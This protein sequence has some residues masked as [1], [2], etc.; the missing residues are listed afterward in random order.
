[1]PDGLTF[2]ATLV[3]VAAALGLAFGV[4][5]VVGGGASAVKP[6]SER[7]PA[8]GQSTPAPAMDLELTA[9]WAIPA[10]R[11][12]SN[13]RVQPRRPTRIAGGSVTPAFALVSAPLSPAESARPTPTAVPRAVVPLRPRVLPAPKPKAEPAPTSMPESSGDFDTT[14]E[15]V[16]EVTPQ[17]PDPNLTSGSVAK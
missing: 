12:S 9:A 10:L 17:V 11:A 14:G 1:M 15:P 2:Q 8:L 16:K 6:T 13:G 3:L 7:G 4:Q 5:V